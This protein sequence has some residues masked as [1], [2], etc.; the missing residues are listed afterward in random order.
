MTQT[1]QLVQLR[2]TI[3]QQF[4]KEEIRLL[5]A[6][7]GE[8]YENLAGDTK[9]TLAL[10]LVELM[11]RKG[12]SLRTAI[13]GTAIAAGSQCRQPG[14]DRWSRTRSP[15]NVQRHRLRQAQKKGNSWG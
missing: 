5:C 15:G 6:N 3:S 8:E 13:Y 7:L 9:D 4:S 11:E 2:K 1:E 12:R 10:S 14:T